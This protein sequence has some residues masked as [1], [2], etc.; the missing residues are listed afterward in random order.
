M[1][2]RSL[3]YGF[4]DELNK[5]TLKNGH[6]KKAHEL[7]WKDTLL[8][9]FRV[10]LSGSD[11]KDRMWR[12]MVLWGLSS[13]LF[14]GLLLRL[15][16]LQIVYGAKNRELADG[17]RIQV[18]V[19]HA[20]RGVIYDRQG[21]ILAANSPGFR[22]VDKVNDKPKVTV[23]SREQ[24][25]EMEVKN[26]PNLSNL[27]VDSIRSYPQGEELAHVIG[28]VGE[29]SP[30]QLQNLKAKG[31]RSGDRIGQ[32]GVESIYED[33]LRGRDGGEIIEVDSKGTSLRVLRTIDPIPGKSIYLTL[34]SDLQHQ[35]FKALSEA[36]K[37]NGSSAGA[38]V[39][40]DP[41]SGQVLAM[42][43][44]PSFNNNLFTDPSQSEGGITEVLSDPASPILNR[45]LGGSYPPGST[46]KIVSSLAALSSG[47][48]TPQTI[49]EDSGE[50]YLGPF[51]FT[52][53]YF[54]QYGKT[55][56]QVD[57]VKAIKRSNDIYFYRVGQTVGEKYL[58]EMAR[59]VYLGEKSGID[60]PG[61][62]SGLI[63]DNDWKVKTFGQ[64]WYPG[65]TL[66][67]AIGQGF[68]LTTP[69]QILG[70]TSYIAS[71]GILYKP[72]LLLKT[73][74]NRQF[75]SQVLV[76]KLVAVDQLRVIKQGLSE[77]PKQGGTA[78][79]FFTFPISSAGKTGTAEFG[80]PKNRTH[81]WYTAFAP[82]DDPKIAMTVLV[83]AGG[84]GSNVAA[85]VVK[86]AFRWY[87]S[88]DKN[89]LIQ[90]VYREATDSGKTLGE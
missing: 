82:A 69:L 72:K 66:H 62:V 27:E 32:A 41:N 55:E 63:P 81:G 3:G 84:E 34:D 61:E 42:V 76:P 8:P 54:T 18:K 88:P 90:D 56:G 16:H 68:V 78:W 52:N 79:P 6:F 33:I 67:M 13:L 47:K 59:K 58:A 70:I 75:N 29:T 17:N 37:K 51:R 5:S 57:L 1:K 49:Y 87:F 35:I 9:N 73:E 86:E 46:F 30:E 7:E 36:V 40:E 14:F 43:S 25:L 38:A 31:Y 20:P 48:I 50:I 83:E 60:L 85:P 39:A 77:V 21:K 45:S 89:K 71:G 2:K 23:V 26:D 80:D 74:D 28:Y 22:L 15:F 12:V 10:D 65:D 53:W 4:V 44:L 11:P 19:I 64:P 24:A